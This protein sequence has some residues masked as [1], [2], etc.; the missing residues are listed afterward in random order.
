M[1]NRIITKKN[2]E[3]LTMDPETPVRPNTSGA[4]WPVLI[5]IPLLFVAFVIV[6]SLVKPPEE[7]L[8]LRD[9][10]D[11]MR[12]VQVLDLK[13]GADWYDL[14]QR[15]LNPPEGVPMH[16]SRL[17]DLP[18]LGVLT[19]AEPLLGRTA[20]V[21]LAATLTPPVLWVGFFAAF[22]WAV[23]PLVERSVWPMAGLV[24]LVCSPRMAISCR[25]G[26]IITAGSC[27]WP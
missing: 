24:C 15:R 27:C 14:T 25:C 26:S 19:L 9:T 12:L 11:A 22:V 18:L 17:P 16:W 1:P 3:L 5:A 6:L 23:M 21:N 8:T 20:A 2:E 7:L 13:D 4:V 10:D